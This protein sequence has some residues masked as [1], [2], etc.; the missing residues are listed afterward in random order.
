MI[1]C[2]ANLLKAQQAEDAVI[3][4]HFFFMRLVHFIQNLHQFVPGL[5]WVRTLG[6][7]HSQL[8]VWPLPWAPDPFV[9]ALSHPVRKRRTQRG[10]Q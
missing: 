8:M 2:I 7:V 6:F 5:C 10:G 4:L 1:T 9:L 3:Q